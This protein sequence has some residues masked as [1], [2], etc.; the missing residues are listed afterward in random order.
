ML[1]WLSLETDYMDLHR[2]AALARRNLWE[3]TM[4]APHDP[5][6]YGEEYLYDILELAGWGLGKHIR[7]ATGA[8]P[9]ANK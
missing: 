7:F 3:E 8:K 9:C 1:P 4:D 2:S 5:V 6:K